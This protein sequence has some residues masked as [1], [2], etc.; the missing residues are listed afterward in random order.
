MLP[1]PHIVCLQNDYWSAYIV[2]CAVME[3]PTFTFYFK[4]Q[5]HL[6]IA[7][8][9]RQDDLEGVVLCKN[10]SEVMQEGHI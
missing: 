5:V 8:S 1:T 2:Q 3:A 6:D 9:F 4:W 10:V 7:G